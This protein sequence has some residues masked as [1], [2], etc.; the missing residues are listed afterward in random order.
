[1][2][3]FRTSFTQLSVKKS[4]MDWDAICAFASLPLL[5][6]EALPV[7]CSV[8]PNSVLSTLEDQT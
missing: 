6:H 4:L 8:F 3:R 5:E 7:D 1:M 2:R